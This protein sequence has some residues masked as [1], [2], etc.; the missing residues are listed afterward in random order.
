MFEAKAFSSPDGR[1][2]K[3][4]AIDLSDQIFTVDE[5]AEFAKVTPAVIR[6]WFDLGL[7]H[8]PT[9]SK[10]GRTGPRKEILRKSVLL[11][12]IEAHEQG[13]LA[14]LVSPTSAS[15]RSVVVATS[16]DPRG[17]M[18]PR[19]RRGRVREPTG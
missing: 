15:P 19:G 10:V 4:L 2:D 16:P 9:V 3:S 13:A 18:T 12:F 8:L 6:R 5:A 11:A 1:M 17:I 14:V 7:K